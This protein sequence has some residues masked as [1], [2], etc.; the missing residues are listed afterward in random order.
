MELELYDNKFRN[1]KYTTGPQRYCQ[2]EGRAQ[3]R[4]SRCLVV[5]TVCLGILCLLLIA[6]IIYQH[7]MC[8]SK[9]AVIVLYIK[10]TAEREI[11]ATLMLQTGSSNQNEKDQLQ[12]SFNSLSQKKLELETRVKDLTAEKGQLQRNFDSLS[13][14]NLELETRVSDLNAEKGQLQNSF[15]SLSQK[16]LELETR[17]SDLN[18]EKGQLQNSFNSLSQKN[19]ELEARVSDLNAEKGQLQNSFNSLSQKN[20]ELESRVSDLNAEKGQLQNSFNSLSQKN[21]E[22]ESRVSDLNAEKGQLQNSFNSLSQKKLE[23]EN[24]VN[25]LT[26]EKGQLQNS[27]NSL[28]QKKLELENT[29]NDLT[30]EKG[31]LQNSFNSLSQKKLELENTFLLGYVWG[32]DGLFIS[33]ELKSWSDSRQYCRDRGAD[34]VIIDT[35][36]KQRHISSLV[37]ESVWIGLSDIENEGTLIWVD[38]SP[39]NKGFFVEGQPNNYYSD[40]DC[41]ELNPTKHALNNW[42][43]F[44]CSYKKKGICEK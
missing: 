33:N 2:D 22:L 5:I 28:S 9:R 4:R 20:L 10:L 15:N 23:L 8:T 19:L 38:N 1:N 43:D 27:F 44:Q 16:N 24:T 32:P 41:T 26:A 42:S 21:L 36:E 18:A 30:A 35:E 7:I 40:E 17:V 25:D 12:N 14:K 3:N 29:V 11:Q 13:Q 6:A 31:Q 37:K 39:L 34:L